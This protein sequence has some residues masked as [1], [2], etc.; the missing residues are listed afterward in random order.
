MIAVIG[1][2]GTIGRA[3][4]ESLVRQD[5][6][7]RALVRPGREAA[8]P[9]GVHPIRGDVD[10]AD[11]LAATLDGAE[12]VFV[13]LPN[14]PEQE[15]REL[16]VVRA[17]STAGVAHFVKVSAPVV[18]N[19]VPVAIARLHHRVEQAAG[20]TE[21]TCTFL[22]PYAFMQN[23]LNHVGPIIAIGAFFGTTGDVPMNFVDARDIAEVAATVLTDATHRGAPLSLTGPEAVTYAE[24]AH[25]L[26]QRGV[27]VRYL[28]QPEQEFR[29]GLEQQRLPHWLVDHLAEIESLAV[30]HPQRPDRTIE[31]VLGKPARTLDEFLYEH[32]SAFRAT[33]G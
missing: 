33:P 29:R 1:A 18:G 15:Q 19:D 11:D 23:L 21:M 16:A 13:A 27:S 20:A 7:V 14:G 24:I 31:R 25:R 22:R 30:T 4:I 2:T 8:L 17:A 9:A 6:C 32:E 10:R 5:V 26:R 12:Q 3:L 28:D